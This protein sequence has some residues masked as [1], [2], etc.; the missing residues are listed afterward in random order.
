MGRKGKLLELAR[1]ERDI[2]RM[3]KSF[4]EMKKSF[5]L[6]YFCFRFSLFASLLPSIRNDFSFA[7]ATYN[8]KRQ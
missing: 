4:V 7:R 2:Q 1:V 3:A 5:S 6:S 8:N